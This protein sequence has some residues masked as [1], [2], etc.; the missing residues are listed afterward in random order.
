MPDQHLLAAVD[1]GSN[2]FRL[3]IGRVEST[4][5][6]EQIRP[7]D[8]LKES[9]RLA[10]G[11]GP[12]GQLDAASQGRA[13]EALS[14]FGERL[15]SF[16]P[17][18]VRAVAT[19][20]FRVAR[21]SRRLLRTAQAALGFPIEVISG[22]EEARL[23]YLGAAHALPSDDRQRIVVDIG[24]GSTECIIGRNYEPV[25]L[26]STAI[27]CV[28]LSEQ[29]FPGGV[30][31][32]SRFER[33]CF[34]AREV[35]AP[36]SLGYQETGWDY[37]LG[38]SGTA[39]AL[40]QALQMN[41]GDARITRAGLQWLTDQLLAAGHTDKIKL[42]GLKPERRPVL[43]GGL[44]VMSAI[45]DELGIGE[46]NYCAGALRQGTL[47]DLLGRN[48]GADMRE[49]TVSRMIERYGVGKRQGELVAASAIGLFSQVARGPKEELLARRRLL[50]W[51]A[52]LAEIGMSISH[53]SFHKHT[54]YILD[55]ADMPGFTLDEQTLM[56]NLALG[57]TGGLRKLEPLFQ[58]ELDWLMAL[59]LRLASTLHRHR[60]GVEITPPA[61]FYK[62]G[63]LRLEVPATWAREHPLSD[64]SLR[65]EADSWAQLGIFHAFEY[66]HL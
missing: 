59:S 34:A 42:E 62:R 49:I 43:A 24:G 6:G 31:D 3:L 26:E 64:A 61:M 51:T 29:F 20:T 13:I 8:A 18:Q 46:M 39:K 60:D 52:R 12:D 40:W 41:R 32:A 21:N 48:Q 11:L 47:Y 65:A 45:F 16:G 37:A 9:V 35:I 19:N 54:A 56:A 57:Q 15:R 17:D 63:G 28:T 30:V 55:H 33:A 58:T 2:S 14:R 5:I 25:R 27:G 50:G 7:L 10:A 23:I 4:E 38:T 53:Q 1:L 36:I 66:Q 44:A 22:H